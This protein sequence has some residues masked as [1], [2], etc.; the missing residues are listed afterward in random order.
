MV[1]KGWSNGGQM[2][3]K[4]V[5]KWAVKR[6]PAVL[7]RSGPGTGHLTTHLTARFDHA[8][9]GD[10]ARR[11]CRPPTR[12]ASDLTAEWTVGLWPPSFDQFV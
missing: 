10:E 2:V 9:E 6:A 1:V 5:V 3:V 8:R 7:M 12:Q 11:I 4:R